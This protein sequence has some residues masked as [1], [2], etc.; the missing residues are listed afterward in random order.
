MKP[1]RQDGVAMVEAVLVIPLLLLMLL[2]LVQFAFLM[3]N[4]LMTVNAAGVGAKFFLAQA[5]SAT[6]HADTLAIIEGAAPGLDLELT[7][8][9]NG[10]ECEDDDCG[11]ALIDNEGEP[12][13]VQVQYN[14]VPLF[15]IP[16]EGLPLWPET[17]NASVSF[18][19]TVAQ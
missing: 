18:R 3:N 19:I 17:L 2:A 15:N 12:A 5:G 4:Y 8:I 6:A 10:T 7:T 11:A 16:L 9:I 14:V 13:T 1:S